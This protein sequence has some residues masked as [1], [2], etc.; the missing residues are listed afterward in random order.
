MFP[1]K[2]KQLILT[3][4]GDRWFIKIIM[5]L[6]AQRGWTTL[7]NYFKITKFLCWQRIWNKT[8][9]HA[10]ECYRKCCSLLANLFEPA[11]THTQTAQIIRVIWTC[12]PF[13]FIRCD[14]NRLVYLLFI[15]FAAQPLLHT[16]RAFRSRIA[17]GFIVVV[18]VLPR[19][20]VLFLFPSCVFTERRKLQNRRVW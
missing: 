8:K 11:I 12:W 16:F 15:V 13:A 7:L 10:S 19:A 20:P 14:A 1:R 17:I 18:A 9:N 6:A 3:S 2:N 5:W 4:M